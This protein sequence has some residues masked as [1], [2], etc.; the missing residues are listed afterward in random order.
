M[1]WLQPSA[2]LSKQNE[3]RKVQ[4][5]FACAP[6]S[7]KEKLAR[8]LVGINCILPCLDMGPSYLRDN[9]AASYAM[10]HSRLFLFSIL[11]AR[12]LATWIYSSFKVSLTSVCFQ[13]AYLSALTFLDGRKEKEEREQFEKALQ[14]K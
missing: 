8:A 1:S 10:T 3:C 2:L 14:D 9:S 12:L 7:G 11:L 4:L 13:V 5:S 6:T